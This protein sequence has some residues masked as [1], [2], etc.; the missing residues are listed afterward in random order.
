[1]SDKEF[2][3]DYLQKHNLAQYSDKDITLMLLKLKRFDRW[4][5]PLKQDSFRRRV[6]EVR[7]AINARPE[8]PDVMKDIERLI[9]E[10][11]EAPVLSLAHKLKLT[12]KQSVST[13]ATHIH[14]Y[15]KYS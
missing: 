2:I 13:L 5:N 7:T 11:P 15:K 3:S 9:K 8:K 10:Y 6:S 12:Y 4:A 1:M 14:N